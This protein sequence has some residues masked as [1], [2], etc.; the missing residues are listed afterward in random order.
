MVLSSLVT[1]TALVALNRPDHP[2]R[3]SRNHA[4]TMSRSKS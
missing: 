1:V 3:N 4:T 2:D